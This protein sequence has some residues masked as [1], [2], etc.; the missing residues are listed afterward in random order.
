MQPL[1]GTGTGEGVGAGG[2]YD[3]TRIVQASPSV[4]SLA[5]ERFFTREGKSPFLFDLFGNPITWVSEDVSVTDDAGKPIYVQPKV[6]KPSFWS[7]LALKVVAS[8]YFWGNMQKG[9]RENSIEQIIRR[10][11]DFYE[12]QA[13]KQR[14]F[15]EVQAR[16]LKEEIAAIC[17]NQL[18][19]FN[20]P[21]WFNVGIQQYSPI[22]GGVAPYKWS[23]ER[24][25][26]VKA[27]KNED[28]PQCSACFIL[29]VSDDMESIMDLQKAEV[30]IFKGGSGAGSNRSSLR[31]SKERLTGGGYSSGPMSF[32]R[33]YDSYAGSIKSGGKTR[34]AA[35]MEILNI[36]H[37]DIL[38]FIEAK[39]REEKKAWALIE[40]GYNGGMNGEAY[41][42]VFFQ[43][44]NMSVR[45]TDEF[46]Q[47]AKHDGEWKTRYVTT[48]E[49]CETFKAR[50]LMRKIAE[51]TWLCGDPG[52]QCDSLI[53][54]YHT[55]KNSGRINASNPCV[56]GDTKVLTAGGAWKRIDSLVGTETT[57]L[58][59][60]GG[61]E[62]AIIAG[63]FVTGRKPVYKLETKAGYEVKLTA[64]H[65]VF[66]INRGFVP[67]CELTKDD[68]VLLPG[69]QVAPIATLS[70]NEQ[71]F[72]QMLGV[73]LG[74][75]SKAMPDVHGGIQITISKQDE[76]P[77]LD[78]F[79]TYV[80]TQYERITHKNSP[81]L[82]QITPT[83][84]KYTITNHA[85]ISR[86]RECLDLGL[87]SHQKVISDTIFALSLAQQKYILQGLFTSDGT[88][89]NYGEKSQYVA[90]DSTSLQL[91][92]D[93]QLL[94]TGFGI[95]SKIYTNRRAGKTTALLPDGKGGLKEYSVKEVHSLRISRQNRIAFEKLIGFMPTSKKAARLHAMNADITTYKELPIDAVKSLTYVGEETVYDLTEPLTH[96]FVANGMTIHNCSEYVFL[97]DTAC[98]LASINLMKFRNE[99]GKFDVERFKEVIKAFIIAMD[100]NVDGA[101]YPTPEIAKNSHLYRTLG[102]GYA[103]LGALLMSLGL[104]YDSDAGRAVAAAITAIMCGEAYKVSAQLAGIVGPFAE[105]A[106]NKEPMLEVMR[107]HRAHVKDINVNAI[108]YELR[109][110][111]NDAWD[112]W[113]AALELGEK[114][115]YRNAQATVLAPTGTIAFMMDC[116][117]TGIEPDI[118]LV[119]YKV[120]AG[121]GMLKIVNRSVP[122]A[123]KNLGYDAGS[124]EAI[125]E[126]IDKNDTIEGAPGLRDEHLPIFDCA[127]KAAKGKRFIHHTGHIKMMGVC[128]PF[129]SGAISKTV[130]MPEHSTIEDIMESYLFA[131]EQGLKAVAIYRENSKRSQ[132][133]NT[134]KTEGERIK[135]EVKVVSVGDRKRLPQ[136]HKSV[137]HKFDIA[138]HHGYVTVGL[139]DD[140]TPG[141][142]FVTM[143]KQGSTIRGLMD[144]WAT[145]VSLNLQYGIPVD[146]LFNK[147]R[148]SKFEPAGFVKN[149]NGGELDEKSP[150]IRNA[151]SIVDYVS[152]FMLNNFSTV[153]PKV[154]FEVEA[155]HDDKEE[156]K[157]IKDFG[158]NEGI[159]CPL[160]GA[161]AKRIGNCAIS[162]TS[163]N[164]T[165]RSGCGE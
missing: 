133:L 92:K 82:V 8:K 52:I 59:N 54:K 4:Q 2:G 10:V 121:G 120:L 117:T 51:G 70:E 80:A 41:K 147:F 6:Q 124:I 86:F 143:S 156:Q 13:L 3:A 75:G 55:C 99:E 115:G 7:S 97:D 78:H 81:A 94:L 164:Q 44:S 93:V 155:F 77:I 102:L 11:S 149:V 137:T 96:S 43:N 83:S 35:K 108:P 17:M 141:E 119:K 127:F 36:D 53:N 37:P 40:A 28:Q 72:Y 1:S 152:Q 34:R 131:W 161:A 139:Y 50:E 15:S 114:Y 26:A 107:M 148:Y 27:M 69:Q 32:L 76:L 20:S 79:A 62:E 24:G 85:L 21:V 154:E 16:V 95:R 63:S 98:N 74:D 58:T 140:G 47:A 30:M 71:T 56:T 160:C 122:L 46:M 153:A 18:A 90:L 162:C 87:Y 66:T 138:G 135:K 106:K 19:V 157:T 150:K 57:I 111:A 132:P 42:S 118:A 142:I 89:A 65:K 12:R 31:S 163:C 39:Q 159:V 158:T 105:Y 126:F 33:G 67:A 112:S 145:S 151:S 165:S 146:A 48:G 136:T 103:N 125:I 23:P 88:V 144:A 91:I 84:G 14:Y 134:Q 123:L 49:P 64:D 110:L 22:A 130:N 29:G 100:L 116:D 113:S 5:L 61:I 9:E 73:Y 104:P 38:E 60:T 109:Y 128:Q 68:R 25:E 45:V 101:S 129:V